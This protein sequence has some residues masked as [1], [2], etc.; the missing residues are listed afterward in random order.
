MSIANLTLS[1]IFIHVGHPLYI[2]RH[3]LKRAM[4]EEDFGLIAVKYT[5]H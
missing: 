3:N 4:D 5:I 1:R 2:S